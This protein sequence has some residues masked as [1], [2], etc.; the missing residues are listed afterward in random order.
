MFKHKLHI[1]IILTVISLVIVY[2]LSQH[3]SDNKVTAATITYPQ[4]SV[5]VDAFIGEN[6]FTLF[7]YS[8]SK[9]LVTFE[10][11]GIYDQTYAD[12]TGYFEFKNR[13]SP[14]APREAC[15]TSQDQLGRT[16]APTCL[17]PFPTVYDVSIGPVLMSPTLSLNQ[18]NYYVGDEVIVSGQTVPN[19]DVS[20]S[21]F[22]DERKSIFNFL[23]WG[24]VKPVQAYT[25]P[26]LTTKADDKGN[27]SISL[28]SSD[29]SYF[30]IFSQTKYKDSDSPQ[31]NKLNL[32]I[33]PVWMI[34]IHLF[35]GLFS[36]LK[37]RVLELIILSESFLVCLFLLRRYLHPHV[38]GYNR[39]LALRETY[40][41]VKE[42]MEIMPKESYL[43][44]KQFKI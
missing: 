8:S 3:L 19:T 38:I 9:A 31:S 1:I 32:K 5:S 6:R 40:S 39:S 35:L 2:G 21:T 27:Y 42:E 14:L 7:G 29:N 10:G 12:E 41:I 23:S 34:I 20:F 26:E 33:Y 37:S 16:T 30:R 4:T 18:D 25:F 44:A 15:L 11:M 17:P 28:P 36:L 43:P 22:I 13:F 24:F